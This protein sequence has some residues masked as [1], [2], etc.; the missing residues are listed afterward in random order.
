[1]KGSEAI[2]LGEYIYNLK[3]RFRFRRGAESII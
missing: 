2:G 3:I 1:M